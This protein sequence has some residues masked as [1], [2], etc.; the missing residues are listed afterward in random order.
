MSDERLILKTS[1][2][3]LG[4]CATLKDE[5]ITL[6]F[7]VPVTSVTIPMNV[8]QAWLV[9]AGHVGDA[10]VIAMYADGAQIA[11]MTLNAITGA[12]KDEP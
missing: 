7:R 3:T 5:S 6:T 11:S 2:G 12:Q 8:A 1:E 9:A 10:R 4:V